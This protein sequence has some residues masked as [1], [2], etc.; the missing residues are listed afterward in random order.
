VIYLSNPTRA[1]ACST[2][3]GD[4]GG[5]VRID[6][7]ASAA[8]SNCSFTGAKAFGGGGAVAAICTS[9]SAATTLSISASTFTNCALDVDS[10]AG[11]GAVLLRGS[12]TCGVRGTVDRSSFEGNSAGT[13]GASSV[14]PKGGALA[15]LGA[16]DQ[17]AVKGCTFTGNLAAKG[18][19]A[20]I[21]ATNGAL[22]VSDSV[23][24]LNGDASGNG[25]NA[26]H[27]ADCA[28]LDITGCK[29]Y[30]T[31]QGNWNIGFTTSPGPF[32]SSF[33]PA[34]DRCLFDGAQ[35]L[36]E[37]ANTPASGMY[38]I[39]AINDGIDVTVTRSTF[40]NAGAPLTNTEL[41]YVGVRAPGPVCGWRETGQWQRRTAE[42]A[43]VGVAVLPTAAR[44][45][46]ISHQPPATSHQPHT[47]NNWLLASSLPKHE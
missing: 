19:G 21:Y 26:V 15:V 44:P 27:G 4:L 40:V 5:A 1:P 10:S 45:P 41:A 25:A 42:W 43:P 28:S 11:G 24:K 38:H 16:K 3:T 22:A 20:G 39:W 9:G 31:K 12:S 30:G 32:V 17:L 37:E 6:T 18:A 34:I 35:L 46:T 8:I 29:F 14:R 23:F 2:L 7:G 36:P 47:I 13:M 33:A